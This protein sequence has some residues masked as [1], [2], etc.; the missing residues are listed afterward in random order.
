MSVSINVAARTGASITGMYI[1]ILYSFTRFRSD[2]YCC[3]DGNT[4]VVKVA[5]HKNIG[6]FS[7]FKKQK[8]MQRCLASITSRDYITFAITKAIRSYTGEVILNNQL[9][10]RKFS[11]VQ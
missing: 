5:V 1:L 2:F 7:T 6:S 10:H 11:S 8:E 3:R 4:V 9:L